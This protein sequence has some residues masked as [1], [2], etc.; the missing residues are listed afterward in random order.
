MAS[1]E[2]ALYTHWKKLWPFR[3]KLYIPTGRSDG[4]TVRSSMYPLAEAMTSPEEAPYPH[5]K[6]KFASSKEDF[7]YAHTYTYKAVLAGRPV[8]LQSVDRLKLGGYWVSG[9]LKKTNGRT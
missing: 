3:K 1:P 6:K 7:L 5:W 2:E 4:I 9:Y 8:R